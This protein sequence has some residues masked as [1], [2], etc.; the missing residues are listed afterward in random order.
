M[1]DTIDTER[2]K[3]D[4]NSSKSGEDGYAIGYNQLMAV[5]LIF[6]MG[7]EVRDVCDGCVWR[8]VRR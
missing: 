7:R 6:V 5:V 2:V 4:S 3:T 8:T 1:R